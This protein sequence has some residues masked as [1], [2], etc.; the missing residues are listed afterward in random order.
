MLVGTHE[1]ASCSAGWLQLA[2]PYES[3]SACINVQGYNR[4]CRYICMYK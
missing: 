1:H 3:I 4:T 2:V